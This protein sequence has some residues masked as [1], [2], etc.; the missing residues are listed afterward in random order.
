VTR[1]TLSAALADDL[2]RIEGHLVAHDD[3]GIDARL[4]EIMAALDLLV[5]HPLIGRPA[6]DGHRELV[7][8]KGSRGYVARYRYDML[9]DE[10]IVL[11][12]RAQREAGFAR[13]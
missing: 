4:D 11:A 6:A 7:V 10:V 8:G 1:L 3:Q 12:L 5:Q 2:E 13:D 9:S